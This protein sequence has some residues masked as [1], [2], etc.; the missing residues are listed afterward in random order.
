ML[1]SIALYQACLIIFLS[2]LLALPLKKLRQPSVIAEVIG[3]ILLGPSAFG[4]IPGFSE[5]IFP[6]SSRDFLKNIAD[7]GLTLYLFLVGLELDVGAMAKNLKTCAAISL[8][9]IIVPF[10]F[11][12]G[13][14]SY[15]YEEMVKANTLPKVPPFSS[16]LLFTGVAMSIT[17]FPV[18]A[19]ILTELNLLGTQVG[20]ITIS[21]AAVDDAMA[22]SLL[23]MVIAIIN[24]R[25]NLTALYVFL[26]VIAFTLFHFLALRPLYMRTVEYLYEKNRFVHKQLVFAGT[27]I[28]IFLSAWVTDIIGVHAIFG[29]FIFGLTIPPSHRLAADMT[30]KLEDLVSIIF[31][32]LYFAFSG[33]KT[34]INSLGDGSSVL[35]LL[36]VLVVAVGGKLTGCTFAS[37]VS[38]LKW[39]ESFSVGILMNT[40]GLVELIVLNLGLEAGVIDTRVFTIMVLM[41]LLTT[42]M[43]TPLIMWVYPPHKRGDYASDERNKVA[44]IHDTTVSLHSPSTYRLLLGLDKVED[45]SSM[46]SLL[47]LLKPTDD[48]HSVIL[49]AVRH[50]ESSEISSNF[51]FLCQTTSAIKVD[52]VLKMINVFGQLMGIEVWPHFAFGGQTNYIQEVSSISKQEGVDLVLFPYKKPLYS[53]IVSDVVANVHSTVAFYVDASSGHILARTHV[54]K[55]IL[56]PFVGGKSHREALAIALRFAAQAHVQVQVLVLSKEEAPKEMDASSIPVSGVSQQDIESLQTAITFGKSVSLVYHYFVTD[57]PQS[58]LDAVS[59]SD[60]SLILLGYYNDTSDDTVLGPVINSL[61]E[62]IT[63]TSMLLI[64][65]SKAPVESQDIVQEEA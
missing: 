29:A 33:L 51:V 19:R 61:L 7:L 55:T 24:A 57:I 8:A 52:P 9:G 46:S 13:A 27:F 14:S 26:L 11:G 50:K 49:H 48:K 3:G 42:F 15:M 60:Y 23:A 53:S 12:V 37:R 35:M 56:V 22:W 5:T 47:I 20:V 36:V 18:L 2:R 1:T 58:I 63:K 25:D 64:K 54:D 6:E 31:L 43:T 28:L 40:K 30:E 62:S 4:Y 38:G 41:A 16:F 44:S 17:A 39:R 32:P 21:A 34:K 10:A 45:I 65:A 59:C